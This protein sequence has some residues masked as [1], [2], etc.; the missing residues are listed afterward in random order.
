M[1]KIL[2]VEDAADLAQVIVRELE[3][4][5][6]EVAHAADGLAAL[7]LH[8]ECAPDLV[9]LDCP[10]WMGWRCCAGFASRPRARCR[11]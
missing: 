1:A 9:I 6:Y 4:A 7:D 2:L 5:G 10:S 8:A 3:A 11:C